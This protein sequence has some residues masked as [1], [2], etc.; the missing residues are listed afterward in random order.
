M[1]SFFWKWARFFLFW[2]RVTFGRAHIFTLLIMS[3][4][5]STVCS[6]TSPPP[7]EESFS[8]SRQFQFPHDI[9]VFG[10]EV[11]VCDTYNHRIQVFSA[12]TGKFV[13]RWGSFGKGD[14]QFYEPRGI[15]TRW[16]ANFCANSAAMEMATGNFIFPKESSFLKKKFLSATWTTIAFKS[17]KRRPGSTCVSGEAEENVFVQRKLMNSSMGSL[18]ALMGSPS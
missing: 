1:T 8:S 13:R 14:G 11:L 9:T 10:E 7:E 12:S 16:L 3:G 5:P 15:T 2:L 18:M 4:S 17:S 6:P